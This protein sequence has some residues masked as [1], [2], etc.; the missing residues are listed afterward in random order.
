VF[1]ISF[2]TLAKA[3]ISK[4][5]TVQS[6]SLFEDYEFFIILIALFSVMTGIGVLWEYFWYK[7]KMLEK[8]NR[9]KTEGNATQ[10]SHCFLYIQSVFLM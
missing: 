1:D 8:M 2:Q 6:R 9:I 3:T 7:P 4:D 5:E 10:I